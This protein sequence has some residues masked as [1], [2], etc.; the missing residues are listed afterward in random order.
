MSRVRKSTAESG[1]I[2]RDCPHRTVMRPRSESACLLMDRQH[3]RAI[4]CPPG[5]MTL[6][7]SP[8]LI[9]QNADLCQDFVWDSFSAGPRAEYYLQ[10]FLSRYLTSNNAYSVQLNKALEGLVSQPLFLSSSLRTGCRLTSSLSIWYVYGVRAP[11][12]TNIF[13]H[14]YPEIARQCMVACS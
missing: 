5:G 2:I 9:V 3:S 11:A 8:T 13:Q 6:C 1:Y 7:S 12:Y 10:G 4:W 14:V